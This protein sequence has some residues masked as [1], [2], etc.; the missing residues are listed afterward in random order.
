MK[1]LCGG[2]VV[3]VAVVLAIATVMVRPATAAP[4]RPAKPNLRRTETGIQSHNWTGTWQRTAGD[5][6]P[7]NRVKV[8]VLPAAE[9]QVIAGKD[10]DGRSNQP[11]AGPELAKICSGRSAIGWPRTILA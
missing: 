8:T 11:F 5:G 10:A 4:K 7:A 9:T 2:A 3:F 1:A 6:H